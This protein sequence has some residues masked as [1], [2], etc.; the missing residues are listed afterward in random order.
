[1]KPG[2]KK[3]Q[4]L[5]LPGGFLALALLVLLNAESM[6]APARQLVNYFSH[7]MFAAS[8]ALSYW[9]NRSRVFFIALLLEAGQ[10]LIFSMVPPGA[11]RNEYMLASYSAA[12]L[13][14]PLN[15]LAFSF[16]KERGILSGPGKF[17][18]AF[19]LAQLIFISWAGLPGNDVA[20]QALNVR[21]IPTSPPDL[22]PIPQLSVLFFVITFTV[23]LARLYLSPTPMDGHFTGILIA[24]ALALHL[25]ENIMA[26]QIFYTTSGIIMLAALIQDSYRKAY[27]DELTGIPGRR[28]LMEELAKLDGKY[29]IAMVDID[30]FKKF[31]DTYGHDV[32]DEVLKFIAA[33]INDVTGGGKAFRYGGEEFTVVFPGKRVKDVLPHLENLREAIGKRPFILRGKD[34]PKEKPE[35]ITP[36][37]STRRRLFITVSIGVAQSGLQSREAGEVI[38]EADGALY[39]AKQQG[40]N[41][42]CR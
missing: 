39:R 28:S 22:T 6:S 3:L 31:N 5:A 1:M 4:P 27:L 35:K 38:R 26:F 33:Q 8:L 29:S 2:I 25:R 11:G 10:L 34:R 36:S 15:I 12:S 16:F 37:K 7:V 42:V 40:R 24:V 13:L 14:L 20:V 18:V 41:R 19:V 17:R 30:F 9:F 21:I 23:L 32:G